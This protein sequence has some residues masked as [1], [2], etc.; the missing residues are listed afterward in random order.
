MNPDKIKQ[1][2]ELIPYDEYISAGEISKK[3]G[4]S[5]HAVAGIIKSALV[6]EYVERPTKSTRHYNV[7]RRLKIHGGKEK[8][9]D[10]PMTL[11]R[12]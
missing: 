6:G 8:W 4:L 3:T 10:G 9:R 5:G 1:V 12:T 7:Y 2:L 11:L